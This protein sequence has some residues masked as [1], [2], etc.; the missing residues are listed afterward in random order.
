MKLLFLIIFGLI[1]IKEE[2]IYCNEIENDAISQT[3]NIFRGID[4]NLNNINY[5]YE[6][7]EL[8]EEL[9]S[10]TQDIITSQKE[11]IYYISQIIKE[12]FNKDRQINEYLSKLEESENKI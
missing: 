4:T 5:T 7:L 8:L 3:K 9:V 11:K 10:I 6:E 1:Y 2:I 12:L